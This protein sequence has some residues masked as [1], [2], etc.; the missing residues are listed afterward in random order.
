MLRKTAFLLSVFV[1]LSCNCPAQS[2][3]GRC[4]EQDWRSRAIK[5]MGDE[6]ARLGL[7]VQGD[8]AFQWDGKVSLATVQVAAAGDGL[9]PSPRDAGK[10]GTLAYVE[11]ERPA[12]V[13]NGLYFVRISPE[14]ARALA[15]KFGDGP[16]ALADQSVRLVSADGR[17]TK[18]IAGI[19][20]LHAPPKL[21]RHYWVRLSI[22]GRGF[23]VDL[24]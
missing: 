11:S 14:A 7:K 5:R 9:R 13:P 6:A 10:G 20:V 1:L 23:W 22:N 15:E 18:E 16:G 17:E 12:D 24:G 8:Y 4:P 19:I 21:F 2:V 3:G